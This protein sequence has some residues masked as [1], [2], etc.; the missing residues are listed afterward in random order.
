MYNNYKSYI[1]LTKNL[2]L[3]YFNK[4]F[5]TQ[6]VCGNFYFLACGLLVWRG[7]NVNMFTSGKLVLSVYMKLKAESLQESKTRVSKEWALGPP[8]L[9]PPH[10]NSFSRSVPNGNLD[11]HQYFNNFW[12]K[13]IKNN[14]SDTKQVIQVDLINWF[15]KK[16]RQYTRPWWNSIYNFQVEKQSLNLFQQY[17]CLSAMDYSIR[18]STLYLLCKPA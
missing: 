15:E 8:V 16:K 1:P 6:S 11:Y 13:S 2:N 18:T 5:D 4:S 17:F 10:I 3:F 12:L 9:C 7:E 14:Y